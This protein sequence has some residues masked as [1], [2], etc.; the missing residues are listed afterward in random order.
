MGGHEPASCLGEA[1]S[2]WRPKPGGRLKLLASRPRDWSPLA[3]RGSRAWRGR[4]VPVGETGFHP[5]RKGF[6]FI[7]VLRIVVQSVCNSKNCFPPPPHVTGGGERR[8]VVG[9]E[10]H[11]GTAGLL[12][13]LVKLMTVE[14]G[15]EGDPSGSSCISNPNS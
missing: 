11:V 2:C 12:S 8:E 10:E 5:K 15:W 13:E 7:S 6:D 9:G 3:G 14:G 1:H 4:G